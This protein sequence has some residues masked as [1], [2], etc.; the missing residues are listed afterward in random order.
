MRSDHRIADHAFAFRE[1]RKTIARANSR[2]MHS[3]RIHRDM[4]VMSV[5]CFAHNNMCVRESSELVVVR[6]RTRMGAWEWEISGDDNDASSI[7]I[8]VELPRSGV[9]SLVG[10]VVR[11]KYIATRDHA[12]RAVYLSLTEMPPAMHDDTPNTITTTHAFNDLKW[13]LARTITR[14]TNTHTHTH[15]TR[16]KCEHI[17]HVCCSS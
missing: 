4:R 6:M 13:T 8:S 5:L 16:K 12:D 2:L 15:L 17:V 10:P 9:T 1:R 14:W 11:N 7:N 3:V